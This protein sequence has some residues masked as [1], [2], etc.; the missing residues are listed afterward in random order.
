MHY[1]AQMFV[2]LFI[3]RKFWGLKPDPLAYVA[4]YQWKYIFSLVFQDFKI[5]ASQL[6]SLVLVCSLDMTQ[7]ALFLLCYNYIN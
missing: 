3:L 5:R 4:R 6:V 7:M 2:C 1:C